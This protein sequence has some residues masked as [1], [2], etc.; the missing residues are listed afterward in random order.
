MQRRWY[1]YPPPSR[2]QAPCSCTG[3]ITIL[4]PIHLLLV[5]LSVDPVD[6]FT[7]LFLSD[8]FRIEVGTVYLRFSVH[9]RCDS[10]A[11]FPERHTGSAH[12]RK[13]QTLSN[14][15]YNHCIVKKK[16]RGDTK[17][18]VGRGFNHLR[19]A[20]LLRLLYICIPQT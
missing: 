16:M 19:L 3:A 14:M 1:G 10:R 18:F 20:F 8:V 2:W 6:R 7:P 17:I 15:I 5:P 4:H 9:C 13:L 11:C 12:S